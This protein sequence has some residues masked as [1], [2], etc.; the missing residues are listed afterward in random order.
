MKDTFILRA[1]YDDLFQTLTASQA[2]EVIQAIFA[3][4]HKRAIPAFS[5]PEA[6]ITF[7]CIQKDITFDINKYQKVCEKRKASAEKRWTA[8]NAKKCKCIHNEDEEI[9]RDENIN[10]PIPPTSQGA[11][12]VCEKEFSNPGLEAFAAQVIEHFEANVQTPVQRRIWYHKNRRHL[13]N[14]LE[15]CG[16]DIPLA[17]QTIKECILYLKKEGLTGGYAAVCRNLP[18]YYAQAKQKREESYGYN[19]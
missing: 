5:S 17:F 9:R 19:R 2:G 18:D 8:R 15:F 4:V 7:K 6:H 16:Q 10:T 13:R 1:N 14:I 11:Q 12:T 3:H